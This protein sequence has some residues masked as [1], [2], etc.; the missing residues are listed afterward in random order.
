MMGLRRV[1][2]TYDGRRA[3]HGRRRAPT[4]LC[5]AARSTTTG[6]SSTRRLCATSSPTSASQAGRHASRSQITPSG[7]GSRPRRSSRAVSS[8]AARTTALRLQCRRPSTCGPPPVRCGSPLAARPL[9]SLTGQRRSTCAPTMC[10]SSSTR[11]SLSVP[12]SESDQQPRTGSQANSWL[13]PQARG[14][15]ALISR[16]AASQTSSNS[17]E[18]N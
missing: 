15:R 7:L 3:D 18:V 8:G 16:R 6:S 17:C 12:D 5:G 9:T 10:S 13:T 14:Q 4:R 11:L 1:A 2:R